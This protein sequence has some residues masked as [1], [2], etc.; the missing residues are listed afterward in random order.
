MTGRPVWVLHRHERPRLHHDLR[1]EER[2]VLR[3]WALPKGLPTDWRRDRLAVAVA[4][5]DLE[6]ATYTD[7]HKT[8]ADHGW[9]AEVDQTGRRMVLDLHGQSGTR[10][11]ALIHTSAPDGSDWL[12]HLL[13]DQPAPPATA[14]GSGPTALR[15]PK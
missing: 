12:C 13:K 11:Y 14:E 15:E 5:H 3:S 9:W 1:L 6:H 2:G 4:D 7:E 10:R 8:I